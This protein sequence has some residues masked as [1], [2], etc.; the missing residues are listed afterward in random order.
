MVIRAMIKEEI[1]EAEFMMSW[2]QDMVFLIPGQISQILNSDRLCVAT[3][4]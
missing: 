1:E 3:T 4:L 2:Y